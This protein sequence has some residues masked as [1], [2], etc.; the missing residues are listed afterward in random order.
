[1]IFLYHDLI[2][3]GGGS[4]GS[5]SAIRAKD[6][7]IDTAILESNDR[8]CKKLLTTGNGRCNITNEKPFPDRYHSDNDNFPDHIITKYNLDNTLDFFKSIGIYTCTLEAGKMYP[9]SLQASSVVDIIRLNLE[10]RNI[11]IY[12]NSKVSSITRRKDG[13]FE[14]KAQD[15]VYT[16]KRVLICT[17][18]KSYPK[19]G[20]DGSGYKLLKPF[21]HHLI[22]PTPGIVQLKLD[23]NRLKAITGVK[24]TSSCCIEVNG[25]IK[26]TEFS[27]ILFTDY[28]I[29]GPGIFQLSRIASKGVLN[30]DSVNIHVNVTNSSYD[31]LTEFLETHFAVFSHRPI[32]DNL[33]G[34]IN[35]KLI[36]IVLKEAGLHDIHTITYDVDYKVRYA[37]YN[38]LTDWKFKVTGTNSFDNAQVTVGGIDTTEVDSHTLQSKL[39]PGLFIGGELLDVDGDC[40]GFNLQWAWS[41]SAAAVDGIY[42]SLNNRTGN[43]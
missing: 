35:K 31:E 18:G 3:I 20:S 22:T 32:C 21:G 30:G 9:I 24:F 11:P 17:G 41:S 42:Q 26:K 10:E 5:I 6:L 29:S 15:E 14:I 39:V 43:K 16:C 28:G 27:E 23:Y 1:M 37:L 19:L 13:I 2:I 38:L 12:Y 7:N 25:E 34:I 4:C 33:I 8:V 40:G 36:P